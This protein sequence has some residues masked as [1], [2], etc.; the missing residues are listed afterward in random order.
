MNKFNLQ[1]FAEAVKGKKIVYLFRVKDEAASEDAVALAFV[2]EN[3]NTISKDA[4]TIA[5]KATRNRALSISSS[6]WVVSHLCS[7]LNL[8]LHCQITLR[9]LLVGFHTLEPKKEPQSP[10]M[11][12]EEKML[13]PLYRRLIFFLRSNSVCTLSNSSGVMMGSWLCST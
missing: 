9:Y 3:G 1:L 11:M 8:L 7:P 2:T 6:R 10:Q 4:D 12:R 13:F 5:L